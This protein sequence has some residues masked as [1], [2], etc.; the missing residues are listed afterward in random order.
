MHDPKPKPA[1]IATETLSSALNGFFI[2][3]RLDLGNEEDFA[4]KLTKEKA[5]A[6]AIWT[7]GK[8]H[9]IALSFEAGQLRIIHFLGNEEKRA[10][11]V[12]KNG[13]HELTIS[14][15][16]QYLLIKGE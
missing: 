14:Q 3:K 10:S 1:Y 12:I 7:T 11:S 2:D 9:K 16:L 8:E 13:V 5:K 6:I 15:N 4:F